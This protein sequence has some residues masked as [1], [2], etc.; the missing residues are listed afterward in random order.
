MP[1]RLDTIKTNKQTSSAG[2]D[3]EKL[4]PSFSIGGNVTWCSCCENYMV[5]LQ[6]IKNKLLCDI[7]IPLLVIHPKELKVGSQRDICIP[8]FLATLFTMDKRC[9]K[10]KLNNR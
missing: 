3:V 4:E 10:P 9:K 6:K 2:E 8:M 7:A 5:F 1:I